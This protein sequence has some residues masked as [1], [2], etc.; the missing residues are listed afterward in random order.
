M[1]MLHDLLCNKS[2]SRFTTTS[3]SVVEYELT[4]ILPQLLGGG[5][6]GSLAWCGV[7]AGEVGDVT[8]T[9]GLLS[10]EAGATGRSHALDSSTSS[11]QPFSAHTNPHH[12]YHHRLQRVANLP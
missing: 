1:V 9:H 12:H 5:G 6:E 2:T 7:A 10:A 3:G 8:V 4:C 11:P